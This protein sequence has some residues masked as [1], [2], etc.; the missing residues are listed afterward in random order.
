MYRKQMLKVFILR[1]KELDIIQG[2]CNILYT[3]EEYLNSECTEACLNTNTNRE[4]QRNNQDSSLL[5]LASG[6]TFKF[7]V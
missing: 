5:T 6:A 1:P 2:S 7:T 3:H 4:I